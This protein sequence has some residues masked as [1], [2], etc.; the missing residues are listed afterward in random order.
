MAKI[1]SFNK[2]NLGDVRL[3][4]EEALASLAESH[5]VVFD[6]GNISFTENTFRTTLN[7]AC[8]ATTDN[9]YLQEVDIKHINQIKK[10]TNLRGVL[11]KTLVVRTH[12]YV[13]VGL[14]GTR[15]LLVKREN[16]QHGAILCIPFEPLS[17]TCEVYKQIKS[18]N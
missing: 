8:T 15:T 6:I 14:K 4:L 5:G 11:L 1:K 10:Y 18:F 16:A 3:A 12:R 17:S 13:V 9:P 7:A 2:A